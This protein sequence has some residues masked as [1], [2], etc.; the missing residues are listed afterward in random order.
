MTLFEVLV[1]VLQA[2]VFALLTAV[3]LQTSLAEEH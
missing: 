1:A 2:Y 3:Y